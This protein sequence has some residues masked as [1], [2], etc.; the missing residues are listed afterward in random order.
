MTK[1]QVN[2]KVDEDWL[3]ESPPVAKQEVATLPPDRIA[4]VRFGGDFLAMV[5]RLAVNPAAAATLGPILD[6]Q[7]RVLNRAA[8]DAFDHAMI[9]MQ[10]ELP[11]VTKSGAIVVREKDATGKRTGEVSQDTPY[12]KWEIM[13]PVIKPILHKYGF[14]L[15]HRIGTAP[16]GRVRVTAIL[17]GHGHTDESCYFDLGADTT[18]SKNNAQAWASSVSYAKRHTACAVLNIVTKGEDDDGKKS[19]RPVVLGDPLL[20]DELEQIIALADAA[21]CPKDRL[22][23]HMNKTRPKGHPEIDGLAKLPRG[24]FDETV[25][26]IRSYEANAAARAKA[27]EAKK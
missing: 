11:V 15:R 27:P 22:V 25:A 19:G 12:A 16:D 4:M 10:P 14:G 1:V 9:E 20:Q 18:G 2:E 7:E 21:G 3:F 23:V 24:R 17:I 6:F 26:A 5:E 13:M 8:R